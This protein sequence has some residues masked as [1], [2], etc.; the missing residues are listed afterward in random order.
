[1]V[2][3][4]IKSLFLLNQLDRILLVIRWLVTIARKKSGKEFSKLLQEE[5]VSAFHAEGEAIK[6]RIDVEKM[7]EANKAF[8]HFKW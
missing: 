8:A 4:L 2:E 7:A 3:Q 1:L 5:M 6:K